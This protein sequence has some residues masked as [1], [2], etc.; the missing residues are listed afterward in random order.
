MV[1]GVDSYPAVTHIAQDS[2]GIELSNVGVLG[3]QSIALLQGIDVF[4][5]ARRASVIEM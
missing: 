4:T 1:I 2:F 5:V 3:E